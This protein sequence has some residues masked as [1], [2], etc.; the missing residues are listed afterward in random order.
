[1]AGNITF[2]DQLVYYQ[3]LTG[4]A[5]GLLLQTGGHATH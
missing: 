1:M 3:Y 2:Y 5:V 4:D